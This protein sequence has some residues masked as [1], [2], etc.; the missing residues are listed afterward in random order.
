MDAWDTVTAPGG[1]D[2]LQPHFPFPSHSAV[3]SSSRLI[4][5]GA[6]GGGG[7]GLG[8]GRLSVATHAHNGWDWEGQQ[9]PLKRLVGH[10]GSVLCIAVDE[11]KQLLHSSSVDCTIKTWSLVSSE[12]RLKDQCLKAA[13]FVSKL[14]ESLGADV[15]LVRTYEGNMPVVIGRLGRDPSKPTVTFYGH[16]DV[17]PA[18]EPD[19]KTDPF[20]CNAINEYLC[21][22]GC[23]DNKGPLLAFIF[24]VKEMVEGAKSEGSKGLPLNICFIFEGEEENASVGFRETL[25]SNLTW[26]EGTQVI[27]ISN[28]NWVGENI[29]CLTYGMRGMISLS[30][31]VSVCTLK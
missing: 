4:S 9:Q 17:Q 14:L 16:Y 8:N 31:Q 18:E 21:G 7:L 29:P 26:F 12:P 25:M 23:S 10:Q 19:W 30:I 24:A 22:R 6:G 28:T 5:N 2:S 15:K 20:E 27:I 3:T 1:H 11:A 13:K